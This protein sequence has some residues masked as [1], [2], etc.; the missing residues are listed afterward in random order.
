MESG[1]ATLRLKITIIITII[2]IKSNSHL[3]YSTVHVYDEAKSYMLPNMTR[4]THIQNVP[5]PG[6]REIATEMDRHLIN[7]FHFL[8]HIPIG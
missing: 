3:S 4:S 8:L 7:G 2:L 1:I 6:L 5:H